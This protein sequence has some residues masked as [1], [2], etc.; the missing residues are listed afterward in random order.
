MS[1]TQHTRTSSETIV[2]RQAIAKTMEIPSSA[3]EKF[4]QPTTNDMPDISV[5]YPFQQGTVE[6]AKDRAKKPIKL[7][8]ELHGAGKKRVVLIMGLNTTCQA[9]DY[10][11]AYFGA[12]GDYTV[13]TYDNR[14]VGWSDAPWGFYGTKDMAID[15]IELMIHLG[16]TSD[17]HVVGISMGGMISL[18]AM[19]LR[20][21]MFASSCLIATKAGET[22]T[23][24]VAT[25]TLL[26]NLFKDPETGMRRNININFTENWLKAKPEDPEFETNFDKILNR[27]KTRSARNRPQPLSGMLS[28]AVAGIR[29]KVTRKQLRVIKETQIPS[30]VCVGTWD[31]FVKTKS[32]E[33]LKRHLN[34]QKFLV[35]DDT[36]HA[37]PSCRPMELCQALIAFWLQCEA[38]EDQTATLVMSA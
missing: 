30:F 5:S 12:Q 8:Y 22:G 28:Q 31:N 18:K 33:Y 25:Y 27:Q 16:W 11:T 4:T 3:K 36:G 1:R 9:W 35:F 34:P 14:G 7:Y 10:Q 24:F 29:H 13:L 20:P 21:E 15:L 26:T 37:I 19:M 38:N 23:P 32:S 2:G 17:V 6:V